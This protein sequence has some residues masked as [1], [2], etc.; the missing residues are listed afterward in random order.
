[1]S[2]QDW[3]DFAKVIVFSAAMCLGILYFLEYHGSLRK[4]H[5]AIWKKPKRWQLIMLCVLWGFIIAA[6]IVLVRIHGS[7]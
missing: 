5:T 7:S 6:V 1:M 4:T 2:K 3:V